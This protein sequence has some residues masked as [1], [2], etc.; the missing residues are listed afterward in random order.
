MTSALMNLASCDPL[1]I[2][3]IWIM[4]I[5]GTLLLL[6]PAVASIGRFMTAPFKPVPNK[7]KAGYTEESVATNTKDY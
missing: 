6:A 5:K 1:K 2:V 3:A 4:N 7:N